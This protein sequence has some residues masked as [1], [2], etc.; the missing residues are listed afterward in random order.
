MRGQECATTRQPTL[1]VAQWPANRAASGVVADTS[2]GH[3]SCA[4]PTDPG[5]RRSRCVISRTRSVSHGTRRA[6]TGER[7]S[8]LAAMAA[9]ET[10]RDCRPRPRRVAFRAVAN[11]VRSGEASA[12]RPWNSSAGPGEPRAASAAAPTGGCGSVT[13][14]GWRALRSCLVRVACR[15]LVCQGSLAC[16]RR[17]VRLGAKSPPSA[18]PDAR[19]SRGLRLAGGLRA[20][21]VP[22][23]PETCPSST[24]S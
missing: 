14:P 19:S 21:S 10:T 15:F 1:E 20:R 13:R 16:C 23:S 18:A 17:V 9:A 6:P 22:H 3:T 7:D 5:W 12:R 8:L 4:I 11:V 24:D 2:P